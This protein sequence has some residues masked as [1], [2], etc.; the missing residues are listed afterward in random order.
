M[1]EQHDGPGSSVETMKLLV[2]MVQAA[3]VQVRR[4]GECLHATRTEIQAAQ[5]CI[6]AEN[7]YGI[8]A[9]VLC[10]AEQPY[11]W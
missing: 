3:A 9:N 2:F 6:R 4:A 8:S 10:I 1:N 7:G 11:F 5:K